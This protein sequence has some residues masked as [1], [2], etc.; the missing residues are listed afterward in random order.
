VCYEKTASNLYP[1]KKVFIVAV[2]VFNF[3]RLSNNF[4]IEL[5]LDS[6]ILASGQVKMC[7]KVSSDCWPQGQRCTQI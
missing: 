7:S 6:A 3:L 4:S 2:G 5:D 1:C